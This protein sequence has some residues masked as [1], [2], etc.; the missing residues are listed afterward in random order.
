MGKVIREPKKRAS[1]KKILIVDDEK[2]ICKLISMN[3]A[4]RGYST[5][6]AHSG[7]EALEAIKKEKPDLII[8]DVKMPNMDGFEVL[9]RLK[10]NPDYARIPII[11]LTVK[12]G[13]TFVDK[14]VTL[15]ADFYL[16]KPFTFDN[17]LSFIKVACEE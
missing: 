15:G 2:D 6:K 8:L 5:N 3:L 7:A 11:M 12:K 16:D 14:G 10:A 9:K 4:T 1:K 13:P 17:L